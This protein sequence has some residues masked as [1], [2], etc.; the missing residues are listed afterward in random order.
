MNWIDFADLPQ[1]QSVKLGYWA[2]SSTKS[3]AM[4]NLTSLQSIEFGGGCFYD[5]SSFSLIGIIE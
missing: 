3:F 1:L 4:S 2:F 5:A